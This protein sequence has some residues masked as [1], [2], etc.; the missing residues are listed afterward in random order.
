MDYPYPHAVANEEEFITNS[1]RRLKKLMDASPYE[2]SQLKHPSKPN[3]NFL[4][5]VLITFSLCC[6][7]NAF[8]FHAFAI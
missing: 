6:A 1:G 2:Q 7:H 3:L 8:N 4:F 5:H